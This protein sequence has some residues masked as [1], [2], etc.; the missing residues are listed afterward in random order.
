MSI[1]SEIKKR[2]K[3]VGRAGK[4]TLDKFLDSLEKGSQ[5]NYRGEIWDAKK[6]KSWQENIRKGTPENN[7]K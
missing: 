7:L 2:A 6:A 5:V 1:L 4:K 3:Q